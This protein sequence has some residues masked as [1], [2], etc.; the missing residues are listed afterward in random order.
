MSFNFEEKLLKLSKTLTTTS[1]DFKH[2]TVLEEEIFNLIEDA[3]CMKNSKNIPSLEKYTSEITKLKEELLTFK[4]QMSEIE[5]KI[6]L[7]STKVMF[8]SKNILHKYFT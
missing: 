8:L 2:F 3:T 1:L 6:E 5:K 4:S 7:N